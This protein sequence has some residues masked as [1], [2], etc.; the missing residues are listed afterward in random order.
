MR[1]CRPL[2][3][4]RDDTRAVLSEVKAVR[5]LREHRGLPPGKLAALEEA[6]LAVTR[7]AGGLGGD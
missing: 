3:V 5:L 7:L 6:A 4:S 2:P 1:A